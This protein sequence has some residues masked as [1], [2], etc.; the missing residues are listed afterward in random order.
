MHNRRSVGWVGGQSPTLRN[1]PRSAPPP[2]WDMPSLPSLTQ[3]HGL[4][5][6]AYTGRSHYSRSST[7]N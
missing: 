2:L 6:H 1:P 4:D 3:D 7:S 5:W